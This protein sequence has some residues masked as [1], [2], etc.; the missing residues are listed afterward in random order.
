MNFEFIGGVIAGWSIQRRT[1]HRPELL[2]GLGLVIFAAFAVAEDSRLLWS[3]EDHLWYPGPSWNILI[4]RSMGYGLAGVLII[5]GL[6]ALEVQRR[7]RA[8]APLIMLGDA[9]Y[10]LYLI[11]V[12]ALLILGASERYLHLLRFVPAWLLAGFYVFLILGGAIVLNRVLEQPLLRF[13]Q[14]RP[15]IAA[16]SALT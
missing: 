2:L 15:T 11:H 7:I 9:S 4:L 13:V 1:I 10:L 8:P 16:V 3:N 6:S 12:P 14:P 5:L